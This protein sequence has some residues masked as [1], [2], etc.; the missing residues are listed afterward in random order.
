MCSYPGTILNGI[1]TLIMMR[2]HSLRVFFVVLFVFGALF[3]G[4]GHAAYAQYSAFG[5]PGARQ[6]NAGAAEGLTPV[7]ASVD[8]GTIPVG[9]TAQVV[10][11]FRNDGA[12]AVETG[13]IRLYP[14]STVSAAVSMN[15]CQDE[16]LPSGAECAIA[17]SVKALQA[18]AYRVEM[19]MS[20]SGRTRLVTATVSGSVE[21]SGEKAD[22][23]TS[24]IEMIP[25]ALDFG[26]LDS[27][28]TLV[29]PVTLRN[30]TSNPI[31]ISDIYIDT[32]EQSGYSLKTECKT[33]A[34][35][36][37]CIAIVSW[38]PNTEGR[39]SGVLV[40]KHD[41]PAGLSSVPLTGEYSPDDVGSADVFPQSIPGKG[42]LVSSQTDID[43]GGNIETASTITVSLVNAGD[44][45]LKLEEIRL[46]G[47]DSGLSFKDNGCTDGTILEPVEA[48]PLTLTWSPTRIG[49]LYDDVQILHD[50]A[51]GVL[52]LPVRGSASA[53]VSQ[54]QKAIVYSGE[55]VKTTVISQDGETV[56][57]G[58]DGDIAAQQ[59]RAASENKARVGGVSSGSVDYASQVKN[60]SSVLD[61]Y[62]ITSFS[63]TRAI[64]NGPG[65][66]RIVFHDEVL[67]LGGVPWAINI[68][69]D[70]I[71]FL[72]DAHRVLL[73]F[74]R[75]LSSVVRSSS[76]SGATT[77]TE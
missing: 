22:K 55:I 71:E 50:G 41:G 52:V 75:S 34:A 14:S 57:D 32:S 9:A 58:S 69:E 47:A 54:D 2:S 23:L 35:G 28:Q 62:K 29:E 25:D 56:V 49:S 51:R 4:G 16:P 19:L 53:A 66:S 21:A 1:S 30:I 42:L 73:L 43:F 24:D 61:G 15:Q 59:K 5:D 11:R 40:V 74:D 12:Q 10:V 3:W 33:L 48:C 77:T 67:R 76:S 37:A 72:Y 26:Q 20:H 17:L 36:Q 65:G 6:A 27:G 7:D 46:S 18:G 31:E 60:P 68:Q 63:P 8:G 39:S 45:S 64:I 44:A 70:G 13:L 38:S